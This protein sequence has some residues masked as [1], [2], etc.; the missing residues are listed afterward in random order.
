MLRWL[1]VHFWMKMAFK[2]K[3]SCPRSCS[4]AQSSSTI[5]DPMDHSK[6]GFPVLYHLPEL[7][8][9]HVHWVSD[10]IQ[11]SH[12]LSSPSPAFNLSQHWGLFQWVGSSHQVAK[13]LKLQL[14]ISSSNEQSGL[15]SH[16]NDWFDLLGV[17][18]TLESL[19]HHNSSWIWLN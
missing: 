8:Q 13:V 15:I 5:C 12:A 11:P 4:V 18:G 16:R 7:A 1:R 10:A 17:Q 9:T 19:L 14:S 6:P 2:S 3:S